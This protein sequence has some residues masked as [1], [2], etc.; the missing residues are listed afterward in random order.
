MRLPFKR[1]TAA[2]LRKEQAASAAA[3]AK[4]TELRAERERVLHAETD[5]LTAVIAID[6]AIAAPQRIVAVHSERLAAIER[7]LAR[8][9]EAERQQRKIAAVAVIERNFA[10]RI[11]A[12]GE[13]HKALVNLTDRYNKY[14]GREIKT[15]SC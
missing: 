12:A 8:E 2:A 6:A 3:A 13:L 4:L 5:D 9:R 10:T 7:E 11:V 1:D 14:V 15:R